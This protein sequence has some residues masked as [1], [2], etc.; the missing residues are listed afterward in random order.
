MNEIIY[1]C[2]WSDQVDEKFIT[3]FI[4]TE[5]AVFK[6]NYTKELFERKYISNIYGKSV[7]VV[8]YIDGKPEGA[9]GLWR[10]D[11]E[12]KEAYQP[13][14]TCVTEACR[15]KGIFSEMTKRSVAMLPE[16]AIIYNFPNNNSYPGYMKMGWKLVGEYY[17]SLFNKKAYLE[18]HPVCMDDEYFHWWAMHSTGFMSYK[19][20][21]CYFLVKKLGKPFCYKVVACVSKEAANHFSKAPKGIY[22]YRS[23]KRTFYNAKLGMPIHIVCKNENVK[24]IPV[25]KIDVI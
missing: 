24:N 11:L 21:D 22:F 13:G 6:G 7:V 15:G 23:V 16:S 8:V 14:D 10:N 20:G 1:D 12:G 3:D 2:R 18:E 4:A 9:R 5:N 17:F 19:C 25:W